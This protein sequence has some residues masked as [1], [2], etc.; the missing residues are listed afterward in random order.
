MYKIEETKAKKKKKPA[1][2]VK[3]PHVFKF[4]KPVCFCVSKAFLT[5]FENFLFFY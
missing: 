5:K 1:A 2:T 4:F 3:N